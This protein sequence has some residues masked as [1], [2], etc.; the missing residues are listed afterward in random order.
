[1]HQYKT[2]WR[3]DTQFWIDH[4]NVKCDFYDEICELMLKKITKD[5]KLSDFVRRT[6]SMSM[7]GVNYP[8]MWITTA[9]KDIQW[10]SNIKQK[11]VPIE[12]VD[13]KT[14]HHLDYIQKFYD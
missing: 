5:E 12:Q 6:M 1:L 7:K 13:T 2:S 14:I 4:K 8:S 11:P 3:N 10:E 9:A